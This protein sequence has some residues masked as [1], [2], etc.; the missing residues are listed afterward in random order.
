[1]ARKQQICADSICVYQ[2][3]PRHLRPIPPCSRIPRNPA[4]FDAH[5]SSLLYFLSV[6]GSRLRFVGR[7]AKRLGL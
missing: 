3:F 7:P 2:P 6:F 1:M 4:Q 5:L